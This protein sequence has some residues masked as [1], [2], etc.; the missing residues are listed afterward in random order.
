M[1]PVAVLLHSWPTKYYGYIL[2]DALLNVLLYLPL[3]GCAYLTF[4]RWLDTAGSIFFA[5]LLG[6]LL[7]TCAETGQAYEATR[8]SSLL[9][10]VTN[11]VGSAMGSVL[12]L[13]ASRRPVVPWQRTID[14]VPAVVVAIWF[15]S[16]LFPFVPVHS[17]AVLA[18]KLE[19]FRIFSPAVFVSAAVGWY[20]AGCLL[21][22]AGARSVT[23]WLFV[24]TLLAPAQ[25]LI[26]PRQPNT[27]LLA[28][29]IAGAALFAFLRDHGSIRLL[30]AALVIALILRGLSP[31]ALINQPNHF[32]WTPFADFIESNWQRSGFV[33]LEKFFYCTA[34]VWALWRSGVRLSTAV[35]AITAVLVI[36]EGIQIWLP[37]RYPGVTDPMLAFFS[38]IILDGLSATAQTNFHPLRNFGFK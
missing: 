36:I 3:G 32:T 14:P 11:T 5:I 33:L 27:A 37:G 17:S 28:G 35:L 1:D 20:A 38:G 2:R 13:L 6:F 22:E 12:A 25:I 18:N 30:A 26:S 9:D 8:D 10:I 23:A 31:F 7:S 19:L 21:A 4:R 16:L 34:A 24:S 15:A 29:A